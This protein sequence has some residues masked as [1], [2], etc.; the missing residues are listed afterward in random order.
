MKTKSLFKLV[1]LKLIIHF[2]KKIINFL[3]SLCYFKSCMNKG[4]GGG[5][6]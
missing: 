6:T 2:E 3:L 5:M 1:A 4:G